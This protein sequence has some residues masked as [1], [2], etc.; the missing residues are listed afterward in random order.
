MEE[1]HKEEKEYRDLPKFYNFKSRDERE[2]ILYA[3]FN[4]VTQD[5]NKMVNDLQRFFKRW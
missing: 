3:N 5:V 1:I 2:R 4:Q